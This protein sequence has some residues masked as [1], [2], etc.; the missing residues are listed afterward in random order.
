M[1]DARYEIGRVEKNSREAVVVSLSEYRGT[2]LID[3]RVFG[4]FHD[5]GE[6]R[7]TSKGVSLRIQR[8]PLLIAELEKARE[9]AERR[10]LIGEGA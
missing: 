3:V 7:P 10:G 8:L 1:D 6:L 5:D 2:P 4:D 9:E